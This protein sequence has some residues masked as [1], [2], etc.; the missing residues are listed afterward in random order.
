MSLPEASYGTPHMP[1]P[2]KPT[3]TRTPS[4][5]NPISLSVPLDFHG[6]KRALQFASPTRLFVCYPLRLPALAYLFL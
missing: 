3:A 2:P 6:L 1:S 5:R 4:H